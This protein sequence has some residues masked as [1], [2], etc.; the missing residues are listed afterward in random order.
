MNFLFANIFNDGGP[1]FMYSNLLILITCIV[2]L[3]MAFAKTDKSEKLVDLIKHLSLFGLVWG[4]LGFFVGMIQSFDAISVANDISPGVLAFGL[5]I[6]LLSPSFG[7]VVFLV[8]RLGIIGIH[9]K[10]K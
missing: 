5:K 3:I 2:M 6:G 1:L 10:T 9:L 7:M 8:S 4:F